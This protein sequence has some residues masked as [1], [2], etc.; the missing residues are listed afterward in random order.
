MALLDPIGRWISK[1]SNPMLVGGIACIAF[2]VSAHTDSMLWF[3]IGFLK[4]I[5]EYFFFIL[6]IFAIIYGMCLRAKGE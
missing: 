6:G 1:P 5:L 3:T 2:N 4:L